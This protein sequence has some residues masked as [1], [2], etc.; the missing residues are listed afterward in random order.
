MHGAVSLRSHHWCNYLKIFKHCMGLKVLYHVYKNC[1]LTHILSHFPVLNYILKLITLC[2]P[3]SWLPIYLYLT[4]IFKISFSTEKCK[5][6]S[7]FEWC[8][9]WSIQKNVQL[10]FHTV[11]TT[12]TLLHFFCKQVVSC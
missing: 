1:P 3:T 11:Y 7:C 5:K 8:Q 12:Q 9:N 10:T 2:G 6:T 4:N